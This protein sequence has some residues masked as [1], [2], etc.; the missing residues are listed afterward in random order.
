VQYAGAFED[1]KPTLRK[2]HVSADDEECEHD[3]DARTQAR[4]A[5][6]VM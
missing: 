1:T 2:Q 6:I 4:H 5:S 3:D